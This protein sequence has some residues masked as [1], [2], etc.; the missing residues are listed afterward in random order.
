GVPSDAEVDVPCDGIRVSGLDQSPDVVDNRPH[1][2][3]RQRLVV[4]TAETQRVGVQHVEPGHLGG[5]RGAGPALG[6]RG[7]VDLVVDIGDIH[8]QVDPEA[9][10]LEEPLE[11]GEGDERARVADV[12]AA[13]YGW[14]ARVDADWA[15][16]VG[17]AQG[18]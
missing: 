9:L 17:V 15:L 13:V 14:A 12:D 16:R 7:V 3:R 5:Q 6:P 2:L 1:R 18:L 8:H 4:G 10:C 11:Q